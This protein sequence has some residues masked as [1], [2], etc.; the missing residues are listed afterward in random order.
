M[1][2]IIGSEMAFRPHSIS[3]IKLRSMPNLRAMS[4]CVRAR[5]C[6]SSRTLRPKRLLTSLERAGV[7]SAGWGG[8]R[9]VGAAGRLTRW[10]R[11]V[12]R[13]WPQ[14][15]ETGALFSAALRDE[16]IDASLVS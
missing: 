9:S 12:E 1:T 16:A 5:L 13:M 7:Q 6:R 10:G 11:G 8:L 2:S 3:L 4:A 15:G 14:C